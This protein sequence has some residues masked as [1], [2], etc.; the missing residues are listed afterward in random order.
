MKFDADINIKE[1]INDM[2]ASQSAVKTG[3][4]IGINK[5][6]LKL[7]SKIKNEKL[8]GQVLNVRSGK[9]RNSIKKIL[10]ETNG[11]VTAT[12]ISDTPYSAKHEFGTVKNKMRLEKSNL[13][14]SI[15]GGKRSFMNSALME[16]EQEIIKGVEN[17]VE[18][19]LGRQKWIKE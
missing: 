17:S 8:N 9:L 16:M 14:A 19:A 6:A 7:I 2:K 4:K 15:K 1:F 5:M 18:N 12:I 10:R 3:L 13:K 11:T